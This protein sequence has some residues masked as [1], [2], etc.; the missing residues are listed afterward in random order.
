MGLG[1]RWCERIE[2]CC[3][4]KQLRLKDLEMGKTSLFQKVSIQQVLE[5]SQQFSILQNLH[6]IMM[7]EYFAKPWSISFL[8]N[9]FFIVLLKADCATKTGITKR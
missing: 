2:M 3:S 4:I 7:K 8:M 1:K 5:E 9:Q 6:I